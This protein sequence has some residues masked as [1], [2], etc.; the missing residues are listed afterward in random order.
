MVTGSSGNHFLA[1]LS[2]FSLVSM[3]SFAQTP[4]ACVASFDKGQTL[5]SEGKLKLAREQF[6]QC[7]RGCPDVVMNECLQGVQKVESSMS[8]V[9]LN[10]KSGDRDVIDVKVTMD[11]QLLTTRLDGKA[12]LVDPGPHTFTFESAGHPSLPPQQVL[13]KEGEKNRQ[14]TGIFE[15]PKAATSVLAS[16]SDGNA[17]S[18]SKPFPVLPVVLGSVGLVAIGVGAVFWIG[19]NSKFSDYETSCKPNCTTTQA[20]E[21]KSKALVGDILVGVGAASLLA[22][23]ILFFVQNSGETK[24]AKHSVPNTAWSVAPI[25]GGVFGS[26]SRS[27]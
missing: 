13:V 15:G 4:Q 23:T 24:A 12:F 20:D 27:F 25:S 6:L 7:S 11:G 17:N 21:V 19:A 8:S 2:A 16:P 10:A 26:L 14:V 22:G 18:G 5:Q 1:L 9:V 3:T